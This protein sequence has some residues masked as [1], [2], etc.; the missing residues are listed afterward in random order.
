MYG[1]RSM[2]TKYSRV[3]NK[4]VLVLAAYDA[5]TV[6]LPSPCRIRISPVDLHELY[7]IPII[8]NILF[9]LDVL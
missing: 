7:L 5:C 4:A 3:D 2:L 9:Q 6:L 1:L 8:F